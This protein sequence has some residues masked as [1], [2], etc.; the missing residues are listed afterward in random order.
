MGVRF[1]RSE[2]TS[3]TVEKLPPPLEQRSMHLNTSGCSTGTPTP[4]AYPPTPWEEPVRNP[5]R[6]PTVGL[7]VAVIMGGTLIASPASAA[8]LDNQAF[9]ATSRLSDQLG[10]SFGDRTA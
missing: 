9:L 7:A 5:L 10:K 8:T 4:P 2:P 3:K 1:G 6:R